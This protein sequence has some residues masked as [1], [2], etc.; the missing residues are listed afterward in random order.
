MAFQLPSMESH[1]SITNKQGPGLGKTKSL[2]TAQFLQ[3]E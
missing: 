1:T 3:D 2:P